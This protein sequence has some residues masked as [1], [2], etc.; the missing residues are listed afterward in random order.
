MISK[1]LYLERKLCIVSCRLHQKISYK[2]SD[3]NKYM[4]CK[5]FKKINSS[6]FLKFDARGSKPLAII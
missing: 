6:C 1:P 3:L 4:L 2:E 5:N